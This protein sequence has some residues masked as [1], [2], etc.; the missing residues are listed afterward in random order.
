MRTFYL[1]IVFVLCYFWGVGQSID[2]SGKVTDS[3]TG[4]DLIGV[5]VYPLGN[6]SA[7]TATDF[8]GTYSLSAEVGDTLVFNFLGYNEQRIA[9]DTRR[10]IDV[11]L[12]P[13]SMELDEVVITALGMK[14]EKKSLGYAT[15][16]VDGESISETR[17]LDMVNSLSGKVAGVNITQAGG[18]LGG[19]G[20]R[21]VIRGETSLAGN[22]GPLFVI[23]GVPGGSNDVASDDVA[24]ISVLKG[25]AA[26]A[27]Y[28]SR[29]AAGVILIT[30][31][32]GAGAKDRIGADLNISIAAQT[33]FILPK[34][35]NQ[36]GQGS[37][38]QY[39]YFDG[40]NGTW[41]DGSISNDD[42]RINWG[43][44]FDGEIRPQ[45]NGY[46]PWVAYPDNVRD[47]YET[48][49]IYNNNVAVYGSNQ[50]GDF[51]LSYTNIAQKGIIPNTGLGTDR[52]DFGATLNLNKD[53]KISANI[54]YIESSSENN[55]GF[56]PRLY[57]RNIDI[58]ALKDYWVPG[59]EELQQLQ[60][61][62]SSNNPYFLLYENTRS[63]DNLRL[64]GNITANYQIT[65]KL[66]LMGRVGQ[67]RSYVEN[68]AQ[69]AFSTVGPNNRFGAFSTGQG[70]SRELN[71][72]FLVRYQEDITPDL[73]AIF[74]FG[75][76]HLE[77]DGSGINSRVDRL[78][79]PDIYNLG[80]RRVYPITNNNI[81]EKRLNSLYGFANFA[82]RNFLYLDVTARNDWSSAL[83]V[84]NNSYFYPSFTLS[85]LV[86]EVVRLPS[87]ISF[88]KLRGGVARVGNDTG[89]YALQDQYFWG[90]GEGG[91]A[92]IVQSNTKANANLKPELTSAW[93]VG[94][95]IRFFNNRFQLDATYYNSLTSNQILRVEVSPTTGYDFILKNAGKIRSTGVELLINGDIIQNSNFNWNTTLNWS[96]DR[97]VVEE[98]DPESPE[99]FLS[100]SVTTHLFVEDRLGERRGALYG[101]G[102][103]R[104]PNGEILYTRSG[105]TQRGGKIFLGNYNPDWMGSIYNDLKYKNFGLGCLVD[106]R[107]GGV[108]Y[109][110]TNYNLNIRGLSEETLLGGIGPDGNYVER[111]YIVPDGMYLDNDGNYKKLTAEVLKESGLSSGGLTG[112]Q[113]W[114]NVMDNEIPEAVIYDASYLKIRELSLSY[115]IP[116][117]WVKQAKMR[118]VSVGIVVRNLAVFT[119]VPNVDAETFSG[120][121]QAGAV[122]G[123]DR[124]GIPSVRNIAFNLNMK[125]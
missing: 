84:N 125:F 54:K 109:S 122:P 28:G 104:A 27:L 97:S 41:P 19:G 71:A 39:R 12:E 49:M 99:A 77:T 18:G 13:E 75:G 51:R 105:D 76:N 66:S 123:L 16:E 79:V 115:T 42:S 90:Q 102:Y 14:R 25:P 113:Y 74:S 120:S 73:N 112:Q 64:L 96:Y 10:D 78:L 52:I 47:F 59:L 88:M 58:Q 118:N 108:F 107:Y 33:P 92:T 103:Q 121:D 57:P 55:Q 67:N 80:N 29:A 22:N 94:T 93:E 63:F 48:G 95:D 32:S 100:R 61:R 43:P 111:E 23:D 6:L 89:P 81:Y 17:E 60:W 56:D 2:I 72:D 21:I 24:S 82:Y 83:P 26:A 34:Y 119:E 40:N 31:K 44:R 46:L 53:F 86:H 15:Q 5:T 38:G 30:T 20:A 1:L 70:K 91:V 4:E 7:G 106:V 114:E 69:N 85:G 110:S 68:F 36:F 116:D 65:P 9:V 35:Q 50:A 8:D 11:S 117:Q 45:F 3:E 98:Y 101:K 37:G 124:G 62:A 87:V